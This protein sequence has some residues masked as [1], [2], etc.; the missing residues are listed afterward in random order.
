MISFHDLPI[1]IWLYLSGLAIYLL[2]RATM[3]GFGDFC[4]RIKRR[5]RSHPLTRWGPAASSIL[6][7]LSLTFGGFTGP[8]L[9]AILEGSGNFDWIGFII[10]ICFPIIGAT[11]AVISIEQLGRR[12]RKVI[13]LGPA[14]RTEPGKDA[15]D[16]GVVRK[17][18]DQALDTLLS[19]ERRSGPK[20]REN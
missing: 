17:F 3:P 16:K 4:S 10:T 14:E 1:Q 7:G 8:S 12:K 19:P 6:L 11:L 20:R 13:E 5:W 9:S 15:D 2:E 18:I